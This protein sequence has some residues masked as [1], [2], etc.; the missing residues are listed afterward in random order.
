M[1]AVRRFCLTGSLLVLCVTSCEN[2]ELV[3][4]SASRVGGVKA[5]TGTTARPTSS[6]T[7][8][9]MWVD[10]STNE[11]GF[12]VERSASGSGPWAAAGTTSAT[13]TSFDDGGRASEQQVCYRVVAVRRNS[14]SN[15]SNSD[16]TTP[17]VAPTGL[18]ATRVDLQT[19]DLAWT[20]NSSA[21][22]GYEV[23]RSTAE[24]GPYSVVADLAA[25]AVSYRESGL[26]SSAYWYRVRAKKDGGFGDFSN[27]AFAP[28]PEAPPA[29]SGTNATPGGS[30]WV[31]ITWV[32][33]AANE[34]G[35]RLQRAPDLASPWVTIWTMYGQNLTGTSN[36]GLTSELQVC[37]RVIAFND[38]GDSPPSNPDC[39]TPPAAPSALTAKALDYQTVD[40]AWADNSATE[41]GYEVERARQNESWA[42]VADLPPNSK[43]Y[44]DV[45]TSDAT[46]W[47]RVRAK[48]DGGFSNFSNSVQVTLASVPPAAPSGLDAR[49]ASSTIAV[50]TWSDNSSN[51]EGFRIERG[52]T[53]TGPWEVAGTTGVSI[54]WFYD[55]GRT[56]EREVCY[57]AVAFNAAGESPSNTDCTTPPAGPTN[58]TATRVEGAV[59]LRWEDNSAVEDG[60]Q[61]WRSYWYCDPD[62]YYGG[63]YEVQEPIVTLGPNVTSYSDT[64]YWSDSSAYFVVALKD[65]GSSDESN[66]ASPTP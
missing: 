13:V 35:F 58:L 54:T 16:C 57:R 14:E 4:P 12:R 24:G 1:R 32:D 17:P 64:I 49:P 53:G 48:K 23:Q 19:V 45:A 34:T 59:E 63:C 41:D 40:L 50:M 10:N 11:D 26:S 39:T 2:R 6:S 46:Y 18:T 38:L 61:V 47:Y 27:L 62:P 7:V 5:P 65:G 31:S 21:E 44:R 52:P 8:Q 30:N 33:N 22:D 25:G 42:A 60:Y 15:P 66:W 3:G 36:Y 20:D 9:V 55:A 28:H 37:Y 56:S 51:E 29:P 43:T